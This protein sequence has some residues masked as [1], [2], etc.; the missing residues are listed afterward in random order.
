MEANM[1]IK[2]TRKK[3]LELIKDYLDS[4]YPNRWHIHEIDILGV[5]DIELETKPNNTMNSWVKLEDAIKEA[6]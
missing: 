3:I 1:T 2:L 5:V 4:E 6:R